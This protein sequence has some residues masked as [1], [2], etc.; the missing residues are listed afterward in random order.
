M[1]AAILVEYE[2]RRPT[3]DLDVALALSGAD[4]LAEFGADPEV[5]QAIAAVLDGL[6]DDDLLAATTAHVD[7]TQRLSVL[8]GQ[9]R[10]VVRE[11]ERRNA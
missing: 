11:T 8:V 5:E 7:L 3:D 4:I 9:R 1:T 10:R 2:L 6:A